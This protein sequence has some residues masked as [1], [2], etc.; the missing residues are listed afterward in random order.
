[1]TNDWLIDVLADLKAFA[2]K[3]EYA[4]LAVQLERTANITASEL[5]AH[6]V[7]ALQREAG[8]WAE[9]NA[10]ATARHH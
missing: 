7:G 2:D 4:A 6:E 10:E 3:N 9:W 1:M 8:A 5:A